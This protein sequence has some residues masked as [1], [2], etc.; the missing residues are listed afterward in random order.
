MAENIDVDNIWRILGKRYT[1]LQIIY[2]FFISVYM[3]GFPMLVYVFVGYAPSHRC[4]PFTKDLYEYGYTEQ[5]NTTY[6]V[7]KYDSCHTIISRNISNSTEVINIPCVEGHQYD[8]EVDTFVVEWNLVCDKAGLGELTQTIWTAGQGVGS[9]IFPSI[10]DRYGRKPLTVSCMIL[11]T[12]SGISASFGNYYI[13]AVLRFLSGAF[14]QGYGLTMYIGIM[15]Q[16]SKENRGMVSA[17]A[18]L[19][20]SLNVIGVAGIGYLMRNINWRYVQMA[21]GLVGFHSLFAYWILDESL[22]WLIANKK[23]KQAK[24]V[25]IKVAR[26]N[27]VKLE[28]VLPLLEGEAEMRLLQEPDLEKDISSAKKPNES[29][30]TILKTKTLLKTSAIMSLTWF[31]NSVVYYGLTLQSVQLSGDRYL[32]FFISVGVELPA[33]IT[34]MFLVKRLGRKKISMI[35]HSIAGISL[36]I[37]VIFTTLKTRSSSLNTAAVAFSFIGKY[38]ITISFSAIFLWTPELFPTNLRNTGIGI[39]SV[40][41]RIGGMFAPYSTLLARHI[42]W[43]PGVIFGACC[44]IVTLLQLLLPETSGKD[45]PQTVEELVEWDKKNENNSK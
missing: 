23:M 36:I 33:M 13:Y 8:I 29:I 38:G 3:A 4:K 2:A 5:Y 21:S 30:L 15:E 22:R 1:V 37:S 28:K 16:V 39:G 10:A 14:Q 6:T 11:L 24:A 20:W 41:A 12:I 7:V 43:G 9:L 31:T 17:L 27:K 32:N 25:V 40:F 26:F 42:E 45:L 34:F 44:G 19:S 35:G 18:S